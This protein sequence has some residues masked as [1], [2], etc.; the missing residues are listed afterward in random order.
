MNNLCGKEF[1]SGPFDEC[2]ACPCLRNGCSGPRTSAMEYP[3]RWCVWIIAV[4]ERFGIKKRHIADGTP[5]SY[6]TVDD[7]IS[8][9]RKDMTR[10]ACCYIENFVL[11]D[12]KWPCARTIKDGSDVVY[13]DRPETLEALRARDEELIEKRKQLDSA[14][15][16]FEA[17]L[18]EYKEQIHHLYAQIE[19]KDDYIDRLAKKAGI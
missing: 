14:K 10:S 8:G 9:R 11:G 2:I 1:L 5:L 17:E 4:M 3:G 7:I 19:R 13:E 6:S 15:A 18:R 12:G 16:V